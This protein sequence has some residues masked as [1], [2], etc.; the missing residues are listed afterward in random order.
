MEINRLRGT[1]KVVAVLKTQ[2]VKALCSGRHIFS[3][4]QHA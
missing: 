4:L 2:I 1:R 3:W